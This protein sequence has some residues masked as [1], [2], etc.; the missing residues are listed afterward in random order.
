M[1]RK[2]KT[3]DDVEDDRVMAIVV[4][5][6]LTNPD[7]IL[8]P[9]YWRAMLE[10]FLVLLEQEAARRPSHRPRQTTGALVDTLKAVVG[11]ERAIAD[12]AVSKRKTIAA[13]QRAYRRYLAQQALRRDS[14]DR[15]L[16]H[17]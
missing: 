1:D 6:M 10:R 3:Q 8:K 12:V 13:V 2:R 17:K 4:Q 5:E 11:E 16:G 14:V 9:E 7:A 15:I